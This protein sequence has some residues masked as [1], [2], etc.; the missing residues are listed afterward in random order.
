MT[1][2]GREFVYYPEVDALFKE[3]L[4]IDGIIQFYL[5]KDPGCEA[6]CEYERVE[7]FPEMIEA[8]G[9]DVGVYSNSQDYNAL[10]THHQYIKDNPTSMVIEHGEDIER[11]WEM[12]KFGVIFYVQKHFPLNGSVAA[13]QEWYKNGLRIM[14]LAYGDRWDI[15]NQSPAEKLGGGNDE[16]ELGLTE[17][18]KQAIRELNR[19]NMLVDI[20][21]LSKPAG[22]EAA[23]ISQAPIVATHAC[24]DGVTEHRRNKSDEELLAIAKTGGVIGATPIVWM[25][26][27]D[28]DGKAGID[29]FVAHVDYMVDV[30][31][32]DHVGLGTDAILD[33]WERTSRHYADEHLAA[34]DRWKRV[35]H[36]LMQIQDPQGARKYSNEDLKKI[37]GLNFLRVFKAVL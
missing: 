2:T 13:I 11:A 24:A 29:D 21:H 12:G 34:M 6:D 33:G 4:V 25:L 35:T 3:T 10:I 17:L 18:G 20:S 30:A 19:L 15:A 26:D 5:R 22:L 32:I 14:Q 31:G 28:G 8:S 9:I 16:P 36:K 27:R 23:A 7:D 37:L 1:L